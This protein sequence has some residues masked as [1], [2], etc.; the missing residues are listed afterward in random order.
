M[1][2]IIKS[3]KQMPFFEKKYKNA[4]PITTGAIEL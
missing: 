3:S 1:E 4:I 2:S